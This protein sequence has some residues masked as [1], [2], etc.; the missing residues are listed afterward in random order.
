MNLGR[1]S[2][3]LRKAYPQVQFYDQGS[4]MYYLSDNRK[5]IQAIV[6]ESSFEFPGLHLSAT[7][8]Y[9]VVL[10]CVATWGSTKVEYRFPD[11]SGWP[12]RPPKLQEEKPRVKKKLQEEL[13]TPELSGF[14]KDSIKRVLLGYGGET[15][16]H[17][18]GS[19]EIIIGDLHGPVL[20]DYGMTPGISE[21]HLFTPYTHRKDIEN[22]INKFREKCI[23]H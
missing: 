3:W 10:G 17:P 2:G 22:I 21:G 8:D 9:H 23:S 6:T 15:V 5:D 1:F 18:N 14:S 11:T 16:K 13:P 12:K 19:E 20:Y 4:G 7:S